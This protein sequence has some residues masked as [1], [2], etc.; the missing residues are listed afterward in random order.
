MDDFSSISLLSLAMLVGCYVAGTIPLAVNFSEEKLKLVTVMGAGLLC[1]TAL[2]VIIPEGVHALYEEILEGGHHHSPGQV[3]VVEA[4]ETKAEVE[5]ALDATGKHE[6]SHE[7]LHACIGIS[8]VLG[9]VFML[10]VDQI[11]SSHVHNAEDPESARA[12]SSKITTTLGL[13]VHAA[14]DGV[15]LGAAASTSQTSVQLIVFVAIM[16]HKAPAAFGLVSFLMH[17][18]LERNRIRKHLLVF[19]LAAPVLA[20]ITFLG[21]SQSSKEALSNINATG[22]A[23]LFS[24]GTFLYVATVHVLPEVGGIGHSHNPAGGNGGKGLSK[25][26]VGALV[27]GCLIPLVLS[28]GHHH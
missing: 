11:G 8:L 15:A 6:H 5:A 3:G 23:M 27:L 18:G 13:V 2:A 22:V 20:M 1:G 19:A 21:L 16:L 7:E 17:A 12:A 14:A 10:L 9:F 26:E 25:V 24:A 28:I 4:S